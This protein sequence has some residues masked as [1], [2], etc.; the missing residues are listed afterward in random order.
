M[1]RVVGY[2]EG[3]ASTLG[4]DKY[5]PLHIP[6]GVYTQ[7]NFAYATVDP[8][9]F[10]IVP[11]VDVDIELYEALAEKKQIDP[12]LKI[13]IAIR[14]WAFDEPGRAAPTTTTFSEIAQSLR[15]QKIFIA[16]VISFMNAYDFDGVDLNW[17]Y[18]RASDRG[19]RSEDYENLPKFLANLK[20]G[21]EQSGSK[22]GLSLAI[23]ASHWYLRYFD[24]K[25]IAKHV[26]SFNM[27][28]YDLHGIFTLLI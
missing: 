20:A 12:S 2:Y 18:P 23:P 24:L 16:S 5:L 14:D 7:I 17:A 22:H 9:T 15:K 21:M 8:T 26:D 19:G 11:A 3:F 25:K 28:T 13:F 27:R 6:D 10:E 1:R 4:Y